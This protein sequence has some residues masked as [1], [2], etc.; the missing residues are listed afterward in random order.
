MVEVGIQCGVRLC[1]ERGHTTRHSSAHGR[2]ARIAG[3]LDLHALSGEST[4]FGVA[5]EGALVESCRAHIY[6]FV[7]TVCN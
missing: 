3:A 1:N 5:G 7:L 2:T 4:R 6:L